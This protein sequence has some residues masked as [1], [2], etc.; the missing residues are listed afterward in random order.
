FVSFH[1]VPKSWLELVVTSC[2]GVVGW[3]G[4]GSPFSSAD[5]GITHQIV[6]RPVLTEP[7]RKRREY[8][9]PQWV[10]D[11]LNARVLLPVARYA[12]GAAL[13]PHLSPFVDD[14]SE[15]YVPA[16]REE[17]DKLRSAAEARR[18]RG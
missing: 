14:A 2:G 10:L 9:Q 7:R 5:P 17:L 15:G 3:E 13:P 12:P 1:Q 8:L 11:S 18:K 4:E 6:D 16:Y